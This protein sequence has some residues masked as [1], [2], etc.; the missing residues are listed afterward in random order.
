MQGEAQEVLERLRANLG[1]GH[2]FHVEVNL[3]LFR[4][5]GWDELV[6][7]GGVGDGRRRASVMYV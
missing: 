2:F 6:E 1:V 5:E 3:L 4:V 7:F